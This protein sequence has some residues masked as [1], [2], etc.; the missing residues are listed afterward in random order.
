[1]LHDLCKLYDI[2]YKN[3]GELIIVDSE[4]E[5]QSFPKLF[6]TAQNNG[7]KNVRIVKKDEIE[8]IEPNVRALH[9]IFCLT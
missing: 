5:I 4:K 8:T 6:K 2:P 1:M 9:A 3:S 7:S